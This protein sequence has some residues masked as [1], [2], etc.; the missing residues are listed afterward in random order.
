MGRR[1]DSARYDL[2]VVGMGSAGLIAAGLAARLDLRVAAVEA[3][4]LGGDCLWTGCVPSKSL[5]AA[6]KVAR[7][8]RTADRLGLAA[9]EA[10]IDLARVWRRVREVRE[11][12]AVTDDSPDRFDSLGVELVFGAARLAGPH[13]VE[14]AGRTLEARY[15]IVCTGSRP[16]RPDVAGLDGAGFQTSETFWELE[17][18]PESVVVIGGGPV[19]TELA[20]ACARLGIRVTLL[21]RRARLLPRDEPELAELLADRLR[22]EGV[23]LELDVQPD[24]VAVEDGRKAVYAHGRRWAAAELLVATG[25]SPNIEGLG[26]QA[27]GVRVGAKGVEVDAR[28]RT[29]LRSVYAAGDVAGRY[30]FTH[31]AASEAALAVRNMF[32][33]GRQAVGGPVPWCTFTD[34]EC[35]HVGLTVAEAEQRFGQRGTRAWRL[36]LSHSDRARAEDRTEGRVVLVSAGGRLVGAHV[37]SPAAGEMINELTLAI[38]SR[39][40]VHRLAE[41]VHVYPT[42]SSAIVQAAAEAAYEYARRYAWLTRID[43]VTKRI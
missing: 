32:F 4:R 34:P 37:L 41:V 2:V 1:A 30:Q 23:D 22:A 5:L 17:Q 43:R 31:S 14:A 16:T 3:A 36:D 35:A 20:Q 40:K 10:E 25:R 11:G 21:Q 24:R 12:I 42:F 38:R 18:P 27:S 15:I 8:A 39:M 19:G 33:P 6:A 28:M 9:F 29:S 7:Q 26:L 13:A